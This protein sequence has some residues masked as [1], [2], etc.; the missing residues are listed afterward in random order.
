VEAKFFFHSPEEVGK[1][2]I[3]GKGNLRIIPAGLELSSAEQIVMLSP[4]NASSLAQNSWESIPYV[5][6]AISP[7]NTQRM[8]F[9]IWFP[10]PDLSKNFRIPLLIESK[11]DSVIINT[12]SLAKWQ[13]RLAWSEEY[14]GYLKI[15]RFG[16]GIPPNV[17]MTIGE[18]SLSQHLSLLNYLKLILNEFTEA[19]PIKISSINFQYGISVLGKSL[20]M[21]LGL[22]SLIF[23]FLLIRK[24][25][26]TNLRNFLGFIT[27][28][29]IITDFTFCKS[30]YDYISERGNKS[31]FIYDRDR[32][33]ESRFGPEFSTLFAKL[34]TLVPKRSKVAFLN[35]RQRLVQVEINWIWFLF[36]SEYQA[37]S[38]VSVPAEDLLKS[39]YIFYY[40]PQNYRH[41]EDTGILTNPQNPDSIKLSTE[42]LYKLNSEV[43]ILRVI[44]G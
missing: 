35:S 14:F 15:N 4:A 28:A 10:Y 27:L 32:E 21:I 34:D 13:G 26:Y 43:K 44:H 24:T 25:N 22:M 33:Y 9:F 18:I 39:N 2:Q 38:R 40:Y 12:Q 8:V 31:A 42:I 30:L 19:E 6:L 3:F 20:T 37:F 1:W 36:M 16:L 23:F 41:D 5:K 17:P 7:V 11:Q 29:F